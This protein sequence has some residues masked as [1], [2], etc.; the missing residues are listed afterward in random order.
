MRLHA[1]RGSTRRSLPTCRSRRDTLFKGETLRAILLNAYGW[2][3]VATIAV[4][5]GW[6]M[7]TAGI[8]LLVLSILGFVHARKTSD[9]VVV[10][11]GV[12]EQ[13]ADQRLSLVSLQ[14]NGRPR[15]AAVLLMES[16]DKALGWAYARCPAS[17]SPA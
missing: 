1:K 2:W 17:R 15:G 5:A 4:W 7:V 16:F 14:E 12:Q 9:T 11:E 13:H 6:G 8:I 3:T 10:T